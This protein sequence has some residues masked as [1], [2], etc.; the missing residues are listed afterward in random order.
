MSEVLLECRDLDK[1]Y[2]VGKLRRRR[3][4]ALKKVN[5]QVRRG[6]VY[7]FLG[8]NGAGKTTTIRCL[9][10]LTPVTHGKVIAFG[11]AS[12]PPEVLFTRLTYC[13]EESNV[14]T[15]LTGREVLTIYGR[16][17][18]MDEARLRKRVDET[19]ALMN[20]TEAADRRLS[21][22][23]KG[24]RQRIGL[25]Q[26]LLPEPELI[27]LDEPT[28]GL[29]PISRRRFRD[30]IEQYAAA[31]TTFFIN[32]HT[33]SEVERSCNRVGI[34][35]QGRLVTELS[36]GE[37]VSENPSLDVDYRV[38]GEPLPGSEQR[39]RHWRLN[40]AD[41]RALAQATAQIADRGGTVT[42]V[43]TRR[44]SLEDY[45]IKIVGDQEVVGP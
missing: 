30:V 5:L 33:L 43:T 32:S 14:F 39:D 13:P 37:L 21:G 20:L 2:T 1:T 25:A 24:M 9:L 27:V 19:L 15:G 16:M 36:P 4:E 17:Y 6:D 22:Y 31:G 7:G 11:E 38:D 45:F 8:Q 35:D 26:A 42:A 44:E 23:S 41:T 34:I 40:V 18:G 10:G 28:R 29:D 12:P 3:V